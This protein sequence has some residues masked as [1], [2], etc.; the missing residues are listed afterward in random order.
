MMGLKKV[1][2]KCK[3]TKIGDA[4]ITYKKESIRQKTLLTY[5]TDIVVL[6]IDTGSD[7]DMD[8]I[9]EIEEMYE[10]DNYS[11][12]RHGHKELLE[13]VLDIAKMSLKYAKGDEDIVDDI[14]CMI[15]K[16]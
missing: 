16:M 12:A 6:L 3:K 9:Y 10:K 15:G 5:L 7:I 4:D 2:E 11:E 8:L 14:G 13:G 1:T